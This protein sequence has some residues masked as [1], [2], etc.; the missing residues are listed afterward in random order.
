MPALYLL[1]AGAGDR[2]V[3][4]DRPGRTGAAAVGEIHDLGR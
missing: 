3:R 1:P 2:L 4:L